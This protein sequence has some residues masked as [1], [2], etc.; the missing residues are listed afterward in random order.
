MLALIP[1]ISLICWLSYH[2]DVKGIRNSNRREAEEEVRKREE[3]KVSPEYNT[4]FTIED[5]WDEKIDHD[6]FAP[7]RVEKLRRVARETAATIN[8]PLDSIELDGLSDGHLIK[9]KIQFNGWIL[10]EFHIS[11]TTYEDSA[12]KPLL[13]IYRRN[14]FFVLERT[15]DLKVYEA[16]V[17][18]NNLRSESYGEVE[19]AYIRRHPMSFCTGSS[20]SRTIQANSALSL[21][22][23]MPYQKEPVVSDGELRVFDRYEDRVRGQVACRRQ[24]CQVNGDGLLE[25]LGKLRNEYGKAQ[26]DPQKTESSAI[27]KEEDHF[28]NLQESITRFTERKEIRRHMIPLKKPMTI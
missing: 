1:I 14:H 26:A 4:R 15:G 5:V 21:D 23:W 12:A 10:G 24:D 8:K 3:K 13:E 25:R 17:N 11:E 18:L 20:F 28:R 19:E 22:F 2:K 9:T 7:E 27:A 16:Y 6:V